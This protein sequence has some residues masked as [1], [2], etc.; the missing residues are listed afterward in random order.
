M[1]LLL[2]IFVLLVGT[3]LFSQTNTPTAQDST[4]KSS[5]ALYVDG[6]RQVDLVDYL[7]K[8]FKIKNSEQK[9]DDKKFRFS[10]F[11]TSS[12]VSGGKTVF[13]SISLAFLL[14]D[15]K[16]TNVSTIYFVP[17]ISTN[18][19]YGLQIQ[20]N[21]WL[22]AN[23][24]NLSGE[25]FILNYPQETWGL[26]GN[27][28]DTNETRIDYVC[29]RIHQNILHK[30]APT[31]YLGIGYALDYHYNVNVEKTNW[32]DDK[33]NTVNFP[34]N[35][36]SSGLILPIIYG[37]RKNSL[38]PQ[39]GY[40]CNLNYTMYFPFLGSNNHWE[41]LFLDVRKYFALNLKKQRILALRSYYWT[42]TQGQAPYLDLPAN[43]WEPISGSSSRGIMQNRYRSNALLYFES[44]YRFGISK[45]GLFGAVVFANV[46]S[47]SEFNTQNFTYW[48]PAAGTGLRIKFNKFSRT[49][50][51]VDF[52][53]SKDYF[54]FYLNIGEVF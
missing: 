36:T 2:L 54:A 31:L 34:T 37:N 27:S 45:N 26:G 21:I 30:V 6:V 32:S 17:Y 1:R 9:R 5:N 19:R 11:P 50:I 3:K 16:T 22:N 13:T 52:G 10:I 47:A 23:K 35:T 14:G 18:N 42:V 25:Y 48:H 44:E 39:G 38:N 53:M 49:N 43:R 41:S 15:Y 8:I 40:M 33:S 20:P 29:A 24:W 12:N 4:S 28:S 7:L 51:A 46:I